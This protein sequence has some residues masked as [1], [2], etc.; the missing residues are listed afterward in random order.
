MAG[1]GAVV[2]V[3]ATDS[4]GVFALSRGSTLRADGGRDARRTEEVLTGYPIT[5]AYQSTVFLSPVAK[6]TTGS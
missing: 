6:S 1:V 5:C 2:M 4:L 3:R